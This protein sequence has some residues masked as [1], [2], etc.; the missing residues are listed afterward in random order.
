LLEQVKYRFKRIAQ[1]KVEFGLTPEEEPK[2]LS[3]E[4]VEKEFAEAQL[5]NEAICAMNGGHWPA[6]WPTNPPADGQM[7]MEEVSALQ[8]DAQRRINAIR[9]THGGQLPPDWK[10]LITANKP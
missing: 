10:E 2:Q 7:S 3:K 8:K 5:E 6:N 4:E 9:A 1:L